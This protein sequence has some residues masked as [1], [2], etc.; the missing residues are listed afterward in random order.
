MNK[1]IKLIRAA[2]VPGS[3]NTFCYGLLKTLN[4]E[5]EVIALASPGKELSEIEKREGVR[6]IA[7]NI[8]RRPSIVKDIVSLVKLIR[9]FRK[10]KPD[11]VHSMSAK[12][13][14]LC[15]TAAWI[16]RVPH[17]IH[18][19]TGLAF[20]T[21]TS[22]SRF[23]LKTTERITCACANH[24]L[25]ESQGVKNDLIRNHITKK[26]LIVLGNGNIRGVD[27]VKYSR[28]PEVIELADVIKKNG[29]F[30][31]L[32]VGRIV[33]D[34]GINELIS[35][36]IRLNKEKQDIRLVLV[37]DY[38]KNINPLKKE[39]DEAIEQHKSIET[40]GAKYGD[41]LLAYYAAS[42]C[43]VFPSYREGFP[44][45]VLEAGAMD[46]P[47][48]VT[49]INGSNEI[50]SN[51]VNGL[52]IPSHDVD[53]IY[54][55]MKRLLDNQNELRTMS[56]NS[57]WIVNSKFEISFVQACLKQYYKDILK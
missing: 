55:A 50:I 11:I 20:P 26:N 53:S 27:M 40:P 41:E 18:S 29:V 56:N 54:N 49:D 25:P 7:I 17:R 16:T 46:L 6:T 1:K 35:A 37:G 47:C 19:F 23:V 15:M 12:C 51:G 9:C 36:F 30:T 10:E 52:I 43:F 38:E 33:G 44:N 45:V 48:I 28:R 2:N 24:L 8:E 42:D 21:A 39:T 14:L 32:F 31:F 3:L 13:G 4:E 57:R 34:K 22:F 5:Y